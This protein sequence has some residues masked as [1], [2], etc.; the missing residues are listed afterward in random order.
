M[1][2]ARAKKKAKSKKAAAPKAKKVAK[3]AP[4]K[5]RVAKQKPTA[6]KKAAPAKKKPVAAKKKAA[7]AKKSAPAK[8]PAAPATL[9]PTVKSALAKA[10]VE[11]LI[12]RLPSPV[13]PI[14]KSLR[15]LVLENAPEAS[16]ALEDGAPA[17]FANGLFARI[18][19][20]E[21]SVLVKFLKGGQLPSASELVG[22]TF[23]ITDFDEVKQ[24]VLRKLVREA[25]FENLRE[26]PAANA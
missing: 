18:V 24:S 2:N 26:V 23:H 14:V 5:K 12:N 21:R 16:E 7:P 10:D 4:A 19:P 6:A 15:A 25:V 13:Q 1:A 17:Y 9:H 20:E 22:D 11:G 8:K 3:K